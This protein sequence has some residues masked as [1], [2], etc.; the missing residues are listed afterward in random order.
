MAALGTAL[1]QRRPWKCVQVREV[2][3]TENVIKTGIGDTF[4]N[5]YDH[6]QGYVHQA[7][8]RNV[9]RV[10]RHTIGNPPADGSS[11]VYV[12]DMVMESASEKKQD[13]R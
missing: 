4:G 12:L 9:L 8:I 7:G 10:K 5:F 3:Y 11:Q 2:R 6:I 1:L 13:S